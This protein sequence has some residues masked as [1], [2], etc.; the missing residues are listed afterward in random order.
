MKKDN[1]NNESPELSNSDI[2]AFNKSD[3]RGLEKSAINTQ[4][5]ISER[6]I[7]VGTDDFYKGLANVTKKDKKRLEDSMDKRLLVIQKVLV[8]GIVTISA[9]LLYGFIRYAWISYQISNTP[10]TQSK[11]IPQLSPANQQQTP[12]QVTSLEKKS[13]INIELVETPEFILPPDQPL[14]LKTAQLLYQQQDYQK[15]K[16]VFVQLQKKLSQTKRNQVLRDYFQLMEALCLEKSSLLDE[17]ILAYSEVAQSQSPVVRIISSYQNSLLHLHKKQYLKA[18]TYA[19]HVLSLLKTADFNEDW[20]ASLKR[21][22]YFIAAESITKKVLALSDTDKNTPKDLWIQTTTEPPLDDLSEL[23][24]RLILESGIEQL[25]AASLTPQIQKLQQENDIQPREQNYEHDSIISSQ[26]SVVCNGASIEE[27]LSRFAANAGLDIIWQTNKE[28]NSQQDIP[29]WA[30]RPVTLYLPV[31]S[32]RQFVNIASGRVGLIGYMLDTDNQQKIFVVNPA[33]YASLKDHLSLISDQALSLWQGYLRTFY[34]DLRLPNANFAIGLL[35]SQR[36]NIPKAI[37]EYKLIANRFSDSSLAPFA[38]LNSSTLKSEMHDYTGARKDL[39]QLIEQYE[40]SEVYIQAYLNLAEAT[41]KD[42]LYSEAAQLYKKVF[43]STSTSNFQNSAS[44]GAAR[45]F[46]QI[47]DYANAIDWINQYIN[48][49]KDQDDRN[50]HFACYLLGK[51]HMATGDPK[52][53]YQAFQGAL[54]KQ[55]SKTEYGETVVALIEAKKQQEHFLDALSIIENIRTWQVTQEDYVEILLLKSDILRSM[56]LTDKAVATLGDRAKYIINPILKTKISLEL[57]CCYI[58]QGKNVQA[59]E[60]LIE[61]LT[62]AEPGPQTNQTLYML[63][64]TCLK[65]EKDMETISFC[66]QLLACEPSPQLR[67][68]ALSLMSA[69]YRHQKDY[70]KAAI[71]LLGQYEPMDFSNE[72]EASDAYSFVTQ[73][74]QEIQ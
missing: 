30:S 55:L 67:N 45:C 17:A 3:K 59:Y 19:Y 71:F 38:L 73:P 24:L 21:D 18:R 65:L 6:D 15:A 25:S 56:G 47:E 23:E 57:T 72:D 54:G 36:E 43:H 70:E 52:T 1:K 51:A 14:S 4:S 42:E 34:D 68:K 26:W 13:D 49:I 37:A 2:F 35:Q 27:L 8:A 63:A 12:L 69:A 53:A 39:T 32:T 40:K 29:V 50:Y 20:A 10:P 5:N 66:E 64:Q 62:Y 46:Y 7:F 61:T 48:A 58:D 41:M 44:F 33:Q 31:V 16:A 28:Q 60:N 11:I 74:A 9:I 22:S